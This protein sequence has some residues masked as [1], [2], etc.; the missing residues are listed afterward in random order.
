MSD[1][2]EDLKEALT[3]RRAAHDALCKEN[4]RLE[5]ELKKERA[6]CGALV[7]ARYEATKGAVGREGRAVADAMRRLL[8]EI[9]SGKEPTPS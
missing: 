5:S 1:S 7:R 3:S 4:A 6:R 9:E 8:A 2:V